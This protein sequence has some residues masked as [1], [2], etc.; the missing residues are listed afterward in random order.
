MALRERI[1]SASEPAVRKTLAMARDAST[2]HLV[3]SPGDL[4]VNAASFLRHIRAENLSPATIVTYMQSVARL[5]EFLA[6]KGMPTDVA[7][8]RREHLEAFLEDL[9]ARFSPATARNRYSGLRAFFRWLADEGEISESP[10]TR[11]RQPRQPERL[12]PVLA[13]DA[14]RRLLAA[15]RE[16][17]RDATFADRRDAAIIRLFLAT[18]ARLAELADLRY[19]PA[20][21]ERHDVGD[22]VIRIRQGKNRRERLSDIGLKGD[23]AL[24]RY[25]RSR[26]KHPQ[27]GLPWLWLGPKGR[28]TATGIA[29]MIKRR[30]REA[31][32][33]NLHPHLL[34]HRAAHGYFS[35]GYLEADVMQLMGWK[36]RDMLRRYAAGAAQDRALAAA[37][38]FNPAD[39]L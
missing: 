6:A 21:P 29:Q 3:S 11:M 33:P 39:E 32:I 12:A 20:H 1:T 28:L 10:M 30:G 17:A 16:G 15:A 26:A 7:N 31:G 22:R 14:I 23:R 37:R 25:L 35:A 18:G 34:R 2:A 38:R 24:D 13:D 8:I 27:A 19:E 36:S 4:A 9:L 5:A